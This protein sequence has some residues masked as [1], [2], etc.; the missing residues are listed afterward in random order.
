VRGDFPASSIL[1][2]VRKLR[3]RDLEYFW[4]HGEALEAV[5]LS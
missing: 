2:T 1:Y 5:G 3:I 4:D